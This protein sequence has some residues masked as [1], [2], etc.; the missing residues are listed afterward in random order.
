MRSG[1]PQAPAPSTQNTFNWPALSTTNTSVWFTAPNCCDA[2]SAAPGRR[3]ARRTDRERPAPGPSAVDPEYVQLAR[4]VDHEHVGLVHSAELPTRRER[5]ASRR[6]AR[7]TDRERA[8]PGAGVVD[9][10]D[11]QPARIIDKEHV[12]LVHGTELLRR[13]DPRTGGRET[14]RS[15][16]ERAAPSAGVVDPEDI[17]L[18]RIIDK[19]HIGLVHGAEL[20]RRRDPRTGRRE[21]LRTNVSVRA[22]PSMNRGVPVLNW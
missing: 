8:D 19:E 6:E 18:A 12:G 5:G 10:E 9:P 21:T 14:L 20:L 17:Q 16:P 22:N 11:V 2:A 13:R 4:L 15:N 1:P 7:R 3:E